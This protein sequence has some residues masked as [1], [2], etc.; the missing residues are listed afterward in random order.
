MRYYDVKLE[1]KY[2]TIVDYRWN[3]VRKKLEERKLWKYKL[4]IWIEDTFRN[5]KYISI[6]VWK[7][8]KEISEVEIEKCMNLDI[9]I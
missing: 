7:L 5:R 4:D 2:I 1:K 6:K 8:R 9:D 3:Q